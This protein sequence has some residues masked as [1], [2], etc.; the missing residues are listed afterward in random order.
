MPTFPNLNPFGGGQAAGGPVAGGT[1]YLVGERGPELFTPNRSG[2]IIPNDELGGM[3]GDMAGA[4][5]SGAQVTVYATVASD[6]D[7]HAMAYQVAQEI[8]RWRR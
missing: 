8:N 6:I 7:I 1:T 5:A 4:G 2:S 3:W